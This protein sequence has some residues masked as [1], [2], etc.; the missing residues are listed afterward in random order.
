[1]QTG[2]EILEYAS[3]NKRVIA[4][5]IDIFI[6]LLIL[7]PIMNPI[8][9]YVFAGRGADV[10]LNELSMDVGDDAAVTGEMVIKKLS[11][12]DFFQKYFLIQFIIMLIMCVYTL[13]FWVSYG[14]TP[15][16]WIVGCKVVDA[17]S[18][19]KP[20]LLKAIIRLFGYIASAAPIGLG[21][22]LIAFSDTKQG[23][24]DRIAGT[25]VINFKHDFRNF[26]NLRNRLFKR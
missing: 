7:V 14:V 25:L 3:L 24:H 11:G 17:E 2:R 1:M 23:L 18:L 8:T 13:G 21:F 6:L 10:L 5:A 9:E 22:V 12:E 16:K 26:E 19:E 4:A 15:G 20:S